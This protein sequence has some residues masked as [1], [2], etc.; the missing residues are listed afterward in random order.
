MEGSDDEMDIIERA[1]PRTRALPR[2]ALIP[3]ERDEDASDDSEEILTSDP[4]ELAE[5]MANRSL[6]KYTRENALSSTIGEARSG[7]KGNENAGQRQDIDVGSPS[8]NRS[9]ELGPIRSPPRGILPTS[10]PTRTSQSS[11]DNMSEVAYDDHVDVSSTPQTVSP[12]SSPNPARDRY[13]PPA[14]LRY[15][16][17]QPVDDIGEIHEMNLGDKSPSYKPSDNYERTVSVNS[18]TIED[19]SGV[20]YN[21]PQSSMSLDVPQSSLQISPSHSPAIRSSPAPA[22][23]PQAELSTGIRHSPVFSTAPLATP[24][25]EPSPVHVPDVQHISEEAPLPVHGRTLRTRTVRQQHPYAIEYAQYKRTMLQA[26][27]TDAIIR[28]QAR[29]HQDRPGEHHAKHPRPPDPEMRGFIVPEDEESQDLYVP[30]PSPPQHERRNARDDQPAVNMGDLL[31]GFGGMLSDDDTPNRRAKRK[32]KDKGDGGSSPKRAQP[33]PKPFPLNA[34]S[35]KT[36]EARPPSSSRQKPRP[37]SS[38][39]A[40]PL[41]SGIPLGMHPSRSA[42]PIE[43]TQPS[44]NDS[45]TPVEPNH[46]SDSASSSGLADS[47]EQKRMRILNRM[48]PAA[49]IRRQMDRAGNKQKDETSNPQKRRMLPQTGGTKRNLANLQQP[50]VLLGDSESEEESNPGHQED[51]E[52]VIQHVPSSPVIR[53]PDRPPAFRSRRRKAQVLSD[54]NEGDIV[55]VS[56]SDERSISSSAVMPK[57]MDDDEISS[58]LTRRSPVQSG[59]GGDLINRMLSR[60]GEFSRNSK[61]TPKKQRAG[62]KQGG[63]KMKQAK[64]SSMFRASSPDGGVIEISSDD[65]KPSAKPR[66]PRIHHDLS[67]GQ[68]PKPSRSQRTFT[69]RSDW[70]ELLD[71][72]V[73]APSADTRRAKDKKAAYN[74]TATTGNL[75]VREGQ[76]QPPGTQAGGAGGRTSKAPGFD[77]KSISTDCGV[78]PFNPHTKFSLSTYIGRGFLQNLLDVVTTADTPSVEATP[79]VAFGEHLD[80]RLSGPDFVEKVRHLVPKWTGWIL[81]QE[82]ETEQNVQRSFRYVALAMTHLLEGSTNPHPLDSELSSESLDFLEED[83]AEILTLIGSVSQGDPALKD[84]STESS[85]SW[86]LFHWFVVEVA[87]RVACGNRRRTLRIS[88]S[89]ELDYTTFDATVQLLIRALLSYSISDRLQQAYD[90]SDDLN[91]PVLE[92]WVCLIHL[93]DETRVAGATSWKPLWI[94]VE[95]VLDTPVFALSYKAFESERR[96]EH[97]FAFSALNMF[98]SQTGR[99]MPSHLPISRWAWVC[100]TI[101]DVRLKEDNTIAGASTRQQRI[102]FYVRT[103][104][105]R[106]WLLHTMWG[107][108]YQHHDRLFTLIYP[109]FQS[110]K[111]A[112]LRD[113]KTDFPPFIRHLDLENLDRFSNGDSAWSIFLKVFRRAII[114]DP[115]GARKLYSTCIPIGVLNFTNE[116]PATDMDLS[117]LLN[118]FAILLVILITDPTQDRA[119]DCVKRIQALISF[120]AADMRS[121]E[122]CIRAFQYAGLLLKLYKLDFAPLASWMRNMVTSLQEDMKKATSVPQRNRLAVLILC[123]LR[124]VAAIVSTAGFDRDTELEYPETGFL[125]PELFQLVFQLD[126]KNNPAARREIRL[127]LEALCNAREAYIARLPPKPVAPIIQDEES[128]ENYGF[129][130]FDLDLN[131]PDVL[132]GLDAVEG[133]T[134]LPVNNSDPLAV[135][136]RNTAELIRATISPAIFDNVILGFGLDD[137]RLSAAPERESDTSEEYA[138]VKVWVGCLKIAVENYQKTWWDYLGNWG[139]AHQERI[140]RIID[141]AAERRVRIQFCYLALKC[142]PDLVQR[143]SREQKHQLILPWFQCLPHHRYTVEHKYTALICD[144]GLA[145]NPMLEGL[146]CRANDKGEHYVLSTELMTERPEYIRRV[147]GNLNNLAKANRDN[148]M[149]TNLTRGREYIAKLFETMKHTW[150]HLGRPLASSADHKLVPSYLEFCNA[151]RTIAAELLLESSV[152][153]LCLRL[154]W[155]PAAPPS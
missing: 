140:S 83:A 141:I 50:L 136:E 103:V 49:W 122:A 115:N 15:S 70:A 125:I 39:P 95:Q 78:F 61:R 59:G 43:H 142:S 146:P 116:N 22:T 8:A 87:A 84:S 137:R 82:N 11:A 3:N 48:M 152:K 21:R 18:T 57:H 93:V 35:T 46:D 144:R 5:I 74:R 97:I 86:L 65:G 155:V 133:D 28:P 29:E 81:G 143:A 130:D 73:A 38:E 154:S 110:R 105:A 149:S 90:S 76:G 72:T 151:V 64:L 10:S 148:T 77:H 68:G 147:L 6:E 47:L 113:E 96:W 36:G 25:R 26:G 114:D 42:A 80:T 138:W 7:L 67:R 112:K 127:F 120:Q 79:V 85:S 102:D 19:Q 124:G 139:G 34:K 145:S 60:T 55:E 109:I 14:H 27:L 33:R 75:Y 20:E 126:M 121:R 134:A 63:T 23:P 9:N 101:K 51:D 52:P 37:P 30:P 88:T 135:K 24:R 118:R 119:T 98:S 4:E 99:L 92:L 13:S 40:S 111:L 100:K 2:T 94:R 89:A 16:L 1:P 71:G 123:L 56:S 32:D 45:D 128:Q 107:W 104:M 69:I 131:D 129:D 41:S 117:R 106:C 54:D 58:W 108:N 153:D 62:Y 44:S 12:T 17:P 66:G 132:A 91:D 31:A 150:E 53:A